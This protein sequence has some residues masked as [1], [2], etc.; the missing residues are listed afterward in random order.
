MPWPDEPKSVL[1]FVVNSIVLSTRYA[2]ARM[3][4]RNREM[5]IVDILNVTAG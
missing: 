1:S 4:S 5:M 3:S 2:A